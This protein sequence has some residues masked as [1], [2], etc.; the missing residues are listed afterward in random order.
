MGLSHDL[1]GL[2]TRLGKLDESEKVLRQALRNESEK[3]DL[4]DM[5]HNVS[6]LILLADVQ[7][8]GIVNLNGVSGVDFSPQNTASTSSI[9]KNAFET[10]QSA[11]DVQKAIVH[12]SRSRIG[13]SGGENS[14]VVLEKSILSDLCRKMALITKC[15]DALLS[16][17]RERVR[18]TTARSNEPRCTQYQS[19]VALAL[20]NKEMGSMGKCM[21]LCQ[22]DF[23]SASVS[24]QAEA[25][26]LLSDVMFAQSMQSRVEGLDD[27]K[28]PLLSD[29]ITTMMTY[30]NSKVSTFCLL[31]CATLSHKLLLSFIVVRIGFDDDK[32][33]EDSKRDE[34]PQVSKSDSSKATDAAKPLE[35][36]LTKNPNHYRVLQKLITLHRRLGRLVEIPR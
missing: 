19:M 11:Y 24:E 21:S 28:I 8:H 15:G 12:H 23:A 25:S 30:K 20:L 9:F 2:Y 3:E 36:F 10:L 14:T 33:R 27:F 29:E 6:S 4:T 32:E 5:Q 31:A 18:P 26:I 13:V 17:E 35:S 22:K 7:L 1:A 34:T 16:E